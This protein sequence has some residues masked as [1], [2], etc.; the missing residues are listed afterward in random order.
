MVSLSAK[1]PVA[2]YES[3]SPYYSIKETWNSPIDMEE[4]TTFL[5]TFLRGQL[6][7]DYKKVLIERIEKSKDT[8]RFYEVGN[9]KYP[10]VTSIISPDGIDYDPMLLTQ[11]AARGTIVHKQIEVYLKTKQWME[12]EDIPEV[13][14]EVEIVTKGSLQLEWNDCKFLAFEKK[15]GERFTFDSIEGELFNHLYRYA[16]RYDCIGT[17]DQKK[18]VIDF[19][20]ASNYER[21]NVEKYMMQLSA[22]AKAYEEKMGEKIE[23]L[24]IIPLNPKNKAGYG[25]PIVTDKIDK[26]FHKFLE[27]RRMFEKLYGV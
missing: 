17:L 20:T 7:S 14:A 6:D 2:D 27:K 24:V 9:T 3:Y 26:Y 13:Q 22:Y 18:A 1:I 4:R 15:F 16:G 10:S 21:G 5:Q 8:I 12:P 23:T 11:Y 19:K 25:G